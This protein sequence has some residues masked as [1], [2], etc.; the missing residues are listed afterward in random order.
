MWRRSLASLPPT[1]DDML[2]LSAGARPAGL[3]SSIRFPSVPRPSLKQ[4]ENRMRQISSRLPHN[5]RPFVKSIAC[6]KGVSQRSS[7][8]LFPCSSVMGSQ[9]ENDEGDRQR[10]IFVRQRSTDTRCYEL[11]ATS[12]V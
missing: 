6:E 9:G 7:A 10:K 5:S 12:T 11:S 4:L 8:R 2:G 1:P 3:A